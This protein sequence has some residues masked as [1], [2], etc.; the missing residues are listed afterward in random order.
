RV[1]RPARTADGGHARDA[2]GKGAARRVGHSGRTY[3]GGGA[4]AAGTA[5]DGSSAGASGTPRTNVVAVVAIPVHPVGY[6]GLDCQGAASERDEAGNAQPGASRQGEGII[7]SA[8]VDVVERMRIS[9]F[10]GG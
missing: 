10:S 9:G 1:R 7:C 8:P 3:A 5:G 6:R 2:A 4:A